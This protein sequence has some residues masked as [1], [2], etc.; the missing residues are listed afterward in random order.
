MTCKSAAECV[1]L[2]QALG[3]TIRDIKSQQREL[4]SFPVPFNMKLADVHDSR[5]PTERP[6]PGKPAA[7]S[8]S[9]PPDIR[10]PTSYR[11]PS[12]DVIKTEPWRICD[13]WMS[14]DAPSVPKHPLRDKDF[15]HFRVSPVWETWLL[16][17]WCQREQPWSVFHLIT[18][19][20]TWWRCKQLRCLCP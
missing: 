6:K 14:E 11:R 10:Q 17:D 9:P 3:E 20:A 12:K 7:S 13:P 2:R 5:Q 18:H 1:K 8:S 19:D 16:L 15:C 4:Y